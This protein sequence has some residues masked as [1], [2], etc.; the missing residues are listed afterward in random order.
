MSPSVKPAV[1]WGQPFSLA[2]GAVISRQVLHIPAFLDL[3]NF[4]KLGAFSFQLFSLE[5]PLFFRLEIGNH[6]LSK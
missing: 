1:F 4:L 2:L 3:I 5:N 6:H